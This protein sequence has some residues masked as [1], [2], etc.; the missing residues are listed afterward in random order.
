[1]TWW[2]RNKHLTQIESLL[3]EAIKNQGDILMILDDLKNAVNEIAA[4]AAL[5][6][7]EVVLAVEHIAK[8]VDLEANPELKAALDSLKASHVTFSESLT[9]LKDKVDSVVASGG[10]AL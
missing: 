1:M 5:A 9:A 8:V 7:D 3:R 4:D 2:W 6:H 10:P